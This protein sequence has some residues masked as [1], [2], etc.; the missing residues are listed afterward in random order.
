VATTNAQQFNPS[1]NNQLTDA[2]YAT[3]S[4]RVNGAGVDAIW[5]S[6]S[7]NKTLYQTSTYVT[8]LGQMMANKGFTNSDANL[9]A[10]TTVMSNILMTSD[11][12]NQLLLVNYA[13]V[14]DV[15]AAVYTGFEFLLNGGNMVIN[16]GGLKPGQ[17]LVFMYVQD[18]VGGR[19]VTVQTAGGVGFALQPDPTPGIAS[20]QVLV[21]DATGAF[22]HSASPMI[23]SL[24]GGIVD[25]PIGST[26]PS[27]G[28]FTNLSS[29]TLAVSGAAT[30]ASLALAGTLNA[31]SAT[32]TG[33]VFT[34]GLD[35]ASGVVDA[36]TINVTGQ[37]NTNT[38]SANGGSFDVL[39]AQTVAATDNSLNVATTAWAKFGLTLSLGLTGFIRFPSWMGGLVIQWGMTGPGGGGFVNFPLT[40]PTNL[41]GIH[42]TPIFNSSTD[43]NTRFAQ[44]NVGATLAGFEPIISNGAPNTI[45]YYLA[46]GN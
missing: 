21:S 44:V 23:S 8:A 27:T 14:V 3:D 25:T 12:P 15:N 39:T 19:T 35:A 6:D 4:T 11:L 41:F 36:G 46:I 30:A 29:A 9:A 10:L 20:I 42:L 5:P 2:A 26:L 28:K 33:T 32:F 24:N 40:F 16:V 17:L 7:A 38:L 13:P 43:T 22:L 37:I 1:Q 31:T 45:C 18:S 34:P